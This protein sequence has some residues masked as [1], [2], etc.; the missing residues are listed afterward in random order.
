M[1]EHDEPVRSI[2]Q[3]VKARLDAGEDAIFAQGDVHVLDRP[4]DGSLAVAEETDSGRYDQIA[5]GQ[6]AEAFAR[7]GV[8]EEGERPTG[9]CDPG[10]DRHLKVGMVELPELLG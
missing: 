3:Q 10:V 2:S 8:A 7:G 5:K 9:S 4:L 1:D 6:A